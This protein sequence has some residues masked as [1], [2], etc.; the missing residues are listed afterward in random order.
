MVACPECSSTNLY[1]KGT[2]AG[3][4]C[5][6][7][8][9]CGRFFVE[10]TKFVGRQIKLPSVVQTCH[11]CGSTHIVRD[12]LLG[13]GGQRYKCTD[14]KKSFST[15]TVYREPVRYTCPYCGG[16]LR[17]SGKGKLGQPKYL[18]TCCGKSCSGDPP[19]AKAKAF[20][21]VNTEVS[22]PYCNS[23]DIIL[24]GMQNGFRK[25]MCNDCKHVFTNLTQSR[26]ERKKE[27]P[28]YNEVCPRCG[29]THII[30]AGISRG[31]Q[32]FRCMACKRTYTKGFEQL[33]L[34]DS[35]KRKILMYRLNLGLP[36]ADIAEAFECSQY[37]VR[38]IVKES[39]LVK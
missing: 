5:Y 17:R 30:S 39:G 24:R 7:C 9:D 27:K 22:C 19:K 32:R 21:E 25:Y 2:R 10:G 20:K 35:D 26:L 29:G 12:G 6:Q 3:K 31:K 16:K 37:Y 15:K 14:C 13:T 1:K 4:Q 34:P 36:V 8:K 23:R 38:K 28:Q 11:Q 18:C 33:E